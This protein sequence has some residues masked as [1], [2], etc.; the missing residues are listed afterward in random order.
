MCI[1]THEE[2]IMNSLPNL[3][4]LYVFIYLFY[5]LI[6][7]DVQLDNRVHPNDQEP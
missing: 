2:K 7:R 6:A 1:S 3:V 4:M 5:F